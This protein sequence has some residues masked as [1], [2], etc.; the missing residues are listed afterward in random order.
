MRAAE[1]T[2]AY[3]APLGK[4]VER[5]S[6]QPTLSAGDYASL[7][8]ETVTWGKRLLGAGQAVTPGPVRD[9]LA[10]VDAGE[11]LNA[12]AAD[13]PRFRNDLEELLRKPPEPPPQPQPQQQNQQQQEQNQQQQQQQPQPQEPQPNQSPEPKTQEQPPPPKPP[14][15]ANTGETQTVGGR[16]QPPPT[17]KTDPSLTLPIQ[18]LDQ[19]RN[20][21]S[22]A[23]LFQ[24]LDSREYKP[25][26][27]KG[28][29]W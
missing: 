16:P 28:R 5:L 11:E 20:Q 21:D 9:A 19:L 6:V 18:K 10:G 3:A 23:Q 13:W 7:A 24:M 2:S 8:Q 4:L 27:K 25:S 17:A 12:K 29:D 14:E 22:P 15:Q 26:S 1:D